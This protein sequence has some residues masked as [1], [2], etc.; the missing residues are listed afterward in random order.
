MTY[1]I[2]ALLVLLTLASLAFNFLAFGSM[3][4]YSQ[5]V[6]ENQKLR[7]EIDKMQKVHE[8]KL[9]KTIETGQEQLDAEALLVNKLT[10]VLEDINLRIKKS[11]ETYNFN[12]L[13]S[14]LEDSRRMYKQHDV[15]AY[16][17]REESNEAPPMDTATD[18]SDD[19]QPP[20]RQYE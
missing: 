14:I 2:P 15:D 11:L 20:P 13:K 8:R 5:V 6:L 12:A 10:A 19:N 16:W 17:N 4:N 9:K 18:Y 3:R 7:K 1:L